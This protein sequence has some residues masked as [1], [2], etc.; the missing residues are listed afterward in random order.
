MAST[1]PFTNFNFAVEVVRAGASAPLVQAA[2]AECDGL[3]MG[4]EFK[5]IRVGG[6]N[7]RQVRLA[8]P[9]T[10][11]QLTLKR[12]MAADSFDLWQWMSDSI[13][14]PGLRAEASVVL[15]AADGSSERARFV[16]GR[17]LPV[18]LKAP[19]LNG[20]DGAVAIEEL[21]LAYETLTVQRG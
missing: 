5:T 18:K 13:A 19:P 17:C 2:F 15:F 10:L 14:D 21:Q 3:E 11:G 8:G 6:S 7:D 16:L 1:Q 9:V 12:G 4:M 20:K